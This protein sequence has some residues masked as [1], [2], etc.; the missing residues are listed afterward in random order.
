M[1]NTRACGSEH[2]TNFTYQHVYFFIIILALLALLVRRALQ[3]ERL[4]AHFI[5]YK[6]CS[7]RFYG[8]RTL[9]YQSV[10]R[11][12]DNHE[13]NE[14]GSSKTLYKMVEKNSGKNRVSYRYFYQVCDSWGPF[15]T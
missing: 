2:F 11:N 1:R 15:N 8:Y 12:T 5:V 9:S 3:A 4:I 6:T 10:G 7:L 14:S 13:K